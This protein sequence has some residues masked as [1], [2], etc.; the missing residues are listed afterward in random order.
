MDM[1]ELTL[2][3]ELGTGAFGLVL[4]GR[5]KEMKVAVKTI[6]MECM[7][8]EDFKEEAKVMM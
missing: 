3:Q 8:V 4:E 2:G 6:R 5:W 1:A 7:S